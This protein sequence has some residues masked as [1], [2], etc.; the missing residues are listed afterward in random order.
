MSI[1]APAPGAPHP[2]PAS[3]MAAAYARLAEVFP[4]LRVE[5]VGAGEALPEGAGW[6]RADR[7][8]AGGEELDAFIAWDEE[9]VLRDYGK[10]ARPDVLATFG[11]HRYAWPA[12]LLIT[13]PW[14]LLGRVP[15][16]PVDQVAYDRAEGRMAVRTGAFACL[17]DDPAAGLPGARVVADE[18]ALRGE[19][20]A[21]VAE[22]LEPLL[23]G[24]GPRMRRRGRAL[25]GMVTDEIVESLW[26]VGHLLGEEPRAMAELE[27]LLP[28]ATRP[29][30]GTA[31][32]RELTG[33]NGEALPTRDR[34]SCCMFY[35]LRPED[36]C[37]TC[38]RTCDTD[39]V[40]KLTA[41]GAAASTTA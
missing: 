34:A 35:T 33:P 20:R 25:W 24:F 4:S 40:S 19:V 6:T 41:T 9:Q 13:L 27:R 11:L 37:V 1:T 17:P 16:F 5:E 26:Y 22:H 8:A 14:F 39:R 12:C 7:L 15:R 30:V 3:P 10:A 36:T 32:F 21:A 31:A 28:G 38:P 23:A 2:L 18:E 29:Y